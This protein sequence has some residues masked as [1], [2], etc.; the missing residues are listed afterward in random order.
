MFLDFTNIETHLLRILL[1]DTRLRWKVPACAPTIRIFL[2]L[3]RFVKKH[4]FR[5][6]LALPFFKE[7]ASAFVGKII[8]FSRG[9]VMDF[10]TQSRLDICRTVLES[11]RVAKFTKTFW[12]MFAK[13]LR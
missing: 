9:P 1:G 12:E 8:C 4:T 5:T 13:R 2:I 11:T 3:A 7:R 6:L 10:V